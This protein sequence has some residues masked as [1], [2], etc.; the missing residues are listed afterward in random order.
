MWIWDLSLTKLVLV[1]LVIHSIILSQFEVI[2]SLDPEK[3]LPESDLIILMTAKTIYP[4]LSPESASLLLEL[5]FL[6]D[7][8]TQAIWKYS[9]NQI[10]NLD[11]FPRLQI[12]INE[13]WGGNESPDI[14]GIFVHRIN[15]TE[16]IQYKWRSE[17]NYS[18]F[19]LGMLGERDGDELNILDYYSLFLKTDAGDWNYI[20]GN[21]QILSGYGL[22]SWRAFP[23]KSD[24]GI[25]NAVMRRGSG[26][27]PYRSG[28]ESWAYRGLAWERT[29]GMGQL[30]GGLSHRKLDG[31][32]Q[33]EYIKVS[34]L[35]L[36]V[37][38]SQIKNR[39]NITETIG[40]ATWQTQIKNGEFGLTTGGGTW[41]DTNKNQLSNLSSS[42]YANYQLSNVK[43]FSEFA[44][45]SK[46]KSAI[47]AGSRMKQGLFYY[48][49]VFR[50]IDPD[51]FA[52]RDNA[53]RNWTNKKFGEIG[54]LQEIWFRFHEIN[55]KVYSDL[56]SGLKNPSKI[57]KKSGHETGLSLQQK[58]N[59]NFSIQVKYKI[60]ENAS[61]TYGYSE[62]MIVSAP[63]S[64]FKSSIKWKR[65]PHH[66]IQCHLQE[67]H[68]QNGELSSRGV[69]LRSKYQTDN[70]GLNLN[71]VTANIEGK[72][73]IY[74]WDVNVP[75]EM[76]SKVFT[77]PSHYCGIK[78]SYQ[79]SQ[80]S[81]IYM[82]LSSTWN[83]W[84]FDINPVVRSALQINLSI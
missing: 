23:V 51:Y 61:E 72:E 24:F 65:S 75:G 10:Q 34:T 7:D 2:E 29:L 5:S 11:P 35:G 27:Q 73:W 74:Y 39:N 55:V 4:S 17:M 82:R 84:D 53:F 16:T 52:L 60:Q 42:V 77:R 26:I 79:A 83:Q 12:L 69:Q 36:H 66:F 76:K 81:E 63:V 43:I 54:L 71:W 33:D 50:R 14:N 15:V 19:T 41:F 70:F 78:L 59:S 9:K 18:R 57:F 25:T 32:I 30:I 80:R 13:L 40:I 48:G 3:S 58:F 68:Q 67:K 28:H 20:F 46:N 45:T 64:T 38:E 37:S 47:I 31:S 1:L 6:T 44:I 21:F 22:V 8:E 56:F 49:L 62:D